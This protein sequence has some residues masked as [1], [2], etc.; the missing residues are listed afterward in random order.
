MYDECVIGI[1]WKVGYSERDEKKLNKF[2]IM[3]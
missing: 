2:G 3:I 1:G